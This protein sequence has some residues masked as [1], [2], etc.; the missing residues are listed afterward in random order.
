MVN[1]KPMMIDHSL[2]CIEEA[3]AEQHGT[4]QQLGGPIQVL[5]MR[6]TPEQK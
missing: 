3:E 2:H 5:A 1:S 6:R 4:D